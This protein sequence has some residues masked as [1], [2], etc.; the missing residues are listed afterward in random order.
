MAVPLHPLTGFK[1]IMHVFFPVLLV[2]A[3]DSL[4]YILSLQFGTQRL[5]ATLNLED[6]NPYMIGLP[7]LLTYIMILANDSIF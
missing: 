5:N 3:A 1:G 4:T 6:N 2:E 7:A